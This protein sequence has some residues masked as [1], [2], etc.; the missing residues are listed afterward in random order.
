MGVSLSRTLH[1]AFFTIC[2]MAMFQFSHIGKPGPVII[3]AI[4]FAI[5][6]LGLGGLAAF[7]LHSRLRFGKF[8]SEADRVLFHRGTIL[9]CIPFLVPIRLSRLREHEFAE[10]PIGSMP[11]IRWHFVDD[12]LDRTRVHHDDA[13]IQ[14]F[15]W[16][17]ARYRLSRWWYF[18]FWLAYQFIRAIFVGGATTSPLAQ[19]F[20]LFIVDLLSLVVYATINPYEGQRN[21]ALAVWLLGISKV[22]T[23]GLSIAFLP[24]LSIDRILATVIGVIII[25]IQAFLTIAVMILIILSGISSWMSLSR[26]HEY[27]SSKR[28][29][30]VRI[31][32]FEH[33]ATKALDKAAPPKLATNSK[34]SS[35]EPVEKIPEQP[36]QP[37]F[38]VS[39]VRRVSKI[40]D[41]DDDYLAEMEPHHPHIVSSTLNPRPSNRISRANS[42]SSRHSVSSLPRGARAHRAS[43]SSKDFAP[44][45]VEL[46]RPTT[47]LAH[48]L[49]S[50]QISEPTANVGGTLR[51]Q[52]S[53][54]SRPMTPAL[55]VAEEGANMTNG[56]PNKHSTQTADVGQKPD[57]SDTTV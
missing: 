23:T 42:V 4:L 34:R 7:A 40:E 39:K 28:L 19:V 43:W 56:P 15:G 26:N 10:R 44:W 1:I 48:K 38:A 51:R 18:I 17:Y 50:G 12:E 32:Y 6:T 11:F 25:V 46:E 37:H 13:Y 24:D 27:F 16:L 22:A 20:G 9:G 8:A 35:S 49:S 3:A 30:G 31:R 5:V 54:N 55:E 2:T 21:N 57:T 33:I 47:A 53:F 14:R 29:E 41:E 45:Q 52:D 36:A